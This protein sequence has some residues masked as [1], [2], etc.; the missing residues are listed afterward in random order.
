MRT[1]NTRSGEMHLTSNCEKHIISVMI[2]GM[3]IKRLKYLVLPQTVT[4]LE[5]PELPRHREW[6]CTQVLTGALPLRTFP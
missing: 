5:N 2:K 6:A 3:H 1:G 4:N